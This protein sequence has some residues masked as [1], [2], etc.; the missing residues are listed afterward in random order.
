MPKK[1]TLEIQVDI[2]DHIDELSDKDQ[3]LINAARMACELAYAPYSNFWVGA[4]V[5]LNTGEIIKGSNQEN[6]AYPSGLCAERTA[7]YWI[8]ANHANSAIETVAVSAKHAHTDNFLPVTPC[9]SCRQTLS[10]YETKQGK[11]I[12]M[13]LEGKNG[14]IWVVPSIESLLPLKFSEDSL[15]K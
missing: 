14:Q 11:S 10:E 4:A 7:V 9:G 6:A 5:Q 2:Y 12:R 8:G 15:N 3:K 1:H 13:I